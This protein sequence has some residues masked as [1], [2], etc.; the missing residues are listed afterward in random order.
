MPESVVRIG[1]LSDTHLAGPTERF[2]ALADAC[3]AD[4]DIILHAGDLTSLSILDVFTGKEVHA[5][6]G[7]MCDASSY[8]NLPEKKVVTVG[9]FT[10]A[11]THGSG[12]A[13]PLPESM[14]KKFRPV[15]CIVFGHTHLPLCER[16]GPVLFV[17]PG[18]FRAFAGTYAIIEVSNSGLRGAIHQ[19]APLP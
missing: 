18:S 15:D 5:V 11:L 13:A 6:R 16:V 3:F 12:F 1:V 17:N 19:V 7:N 4:T 14:W 2:K 9:G 10:I 8:H